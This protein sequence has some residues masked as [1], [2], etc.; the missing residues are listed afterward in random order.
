[1]AVCSRRSKRRPCRCPAQRSHPTLPLR[2]VIDDLPASYA[3]G[4]DEATKA[5]VDKG[6]YVARLGDCVA[7]HTGDKNKPLAGG[8]ALTT[9]FG[10][11]YS[12]NITPDPKPASGAI[13]SSSSSG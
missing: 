9:P 1:M 6:R 7:C 10:K 5:L 4:L 2:Q 13:A 12:T 8:L 11:L 3:D